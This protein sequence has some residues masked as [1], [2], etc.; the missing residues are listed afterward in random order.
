MAQDISDV[1]AF[2]HQHCDIYCMDKVLQNTVLFAVLESLVF[3]WYI[4][5]GVL[6]NLDIV[7][8]CNESSDTYACFYQLGLK[9]AR[10]ILGLS[11]GVLSTFSNL[12]TANLGL[13][14]TCSV[15]YK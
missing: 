10:F 14:V 9:N 11:F 7:F 5:T 2:V 6:Q 1:L 12:G 4:L 8:T 3:S 15:I 13:T